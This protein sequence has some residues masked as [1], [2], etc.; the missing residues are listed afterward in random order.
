V[1]IV[2]VIRDDIGFLLAL[3]VELQKHDIGLM[4][5]RSTSEARNAPRKWHVQPN[6]LVIDASTLQECRFA[7]EMR[8]RIPG[9]KVLGVLSGKGG[10]REMVD[11]FLKDDKPG[12]P[13][14]I[15][16]WVKAIRRALAPIGVIKT[17]Q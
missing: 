1:A 3:A 2:L 11:G 5:A 4:A 10:C 7:A 12:Q 9:L 14:D 17:A 15:R 16:T 8:G 13:R 6:L